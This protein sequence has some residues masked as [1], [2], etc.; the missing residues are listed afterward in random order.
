MTWV[1]W[2]FVSIRLEILFIS[3]QDRCTVF[4]KRT[5]GSEIILDAPNETPKFVGH[6]ESCYYLF[7]GSVS[8]IARYV[9]DL[10]Q[11]YHRLRNHF[12]RT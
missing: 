10:R 3:V 2:N 4:A 7:G 5:I 8:F 9:H 11:T 6:V 12:G 1:T